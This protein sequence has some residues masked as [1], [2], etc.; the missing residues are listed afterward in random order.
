MREGNG[1]R[2]QSLFLLNKILDP[3]LKF[4]DR[5]IFG[6]RLSSLFINLRKGVYCI[7]NSTIWLSVAYYQLRQS[8]SGS[9]DVLKREFSGIKLIRYEFLK[10]KKLIRYE[11]IDFLLPFVPFL[12]LILSIFVICGKHRINWKNNST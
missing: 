10:K 5:H 9:K 6:W 4:L 2:P 11:F 12:R 3:R 8:S 7:S 1:Y